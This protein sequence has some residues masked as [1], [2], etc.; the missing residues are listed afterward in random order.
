MS[1]R[2]VPSKPFPELEFPLVGGGTFTLADNHPPFM[3]VL[4][5][6]RGLHCPR[7]KAQLADFTTHLGQLT[8]LGAD[9]VS[10]SMDPVERAEKTVAD[11]GLSETRVG[12]GLSETQ[13]RDLGL[14][15]SQ[16][17][18]DT[19]TSLFAEAGLF[20]IRSDGTYYGGVIN[21]FPF[22]R[23]TAAM[24]L[25]VLKAAVGGYPPRGTAG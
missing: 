21:T 10:V 7:C 3:T 13:A 16:S 22:M 25:D 8:E 17:I 24:L 14:Y 5:V 19:E 4:N 9:L 11:W 6:F 23:P 15:I 12:Y 20:L 2:P 1:N 18:K